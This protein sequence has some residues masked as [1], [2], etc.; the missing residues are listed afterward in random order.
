MA[1]GMVYDGSLDPLRCLVT[2]A[3]S[4]IGLSIVR[5]F[6]ACGAIVLA[7]GRDPAKCERFQQEIRDESGNQEAHFYSADLSRQGE[8]RSLVRQLED[9]VRGVDVLVNNVGALF[10]KR[11]LTSEGFERTFALNH[12]SYFLLTGLLLEDLCSYRAGRV[13][14][15]SSFAHRL[16]RPHLKDPQFERCYI[17]WYAYCH[18]KLANML[19]TY[20]LARRVDPTRLTVNA[21]DPGLVDTSLGLEGGGITGWVKPFLNLWARGVEEVVED[22]EMLA[23]SPSFEGRSGGYYRGGGAVSSSASSRDRASAARLWR[24]S[25]E[26]T[27]CR[28]P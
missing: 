15:I 14:N 22:V 6:A 17:G 28:Y 12:L 18:S 16:A 23:G 21:V 2:G 8:I 5:D 26:L 19:F 13:I 1:D 25:E 7:V 11:A 3:T 10:G 4:G 24:L 9:D 20:E 27:G